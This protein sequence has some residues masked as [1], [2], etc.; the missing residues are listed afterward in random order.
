[1]RH[2]FFALATSLVALTGTALAEDS[3]IKVG[4][5]LEVNYTYNSNSPAATAVPTGLY[6]GNG[7]YFNK[8]S[9]EFSLNF[10]ELHIYKDKTAKEPGF[11]LR[12]VDGEVKPGLPLNAPGYNTSTGNLYEAVISEQLTSKLALD[13]GIF[14]TWVGYE[15][16]PM[17]SGNFFSKSFHFGQ[18]QPFYHG[19]VKASLT[20]SEKTTLVG[21]VV[22]RFSGVET[23]GNKDL[24]LGFQLAHVISEAS[25]IY[26]NGLASRDTVAVVPATTAEKQR[27]I[28]N[29]VYTRKLSG[30][31]NFA[32][33][34][35]VTSGKD[36]ANK[37]YNGQAVT[38]YYTTVLSNGNT[39]G[40]R[41]ESLTAD[42][43]T[44]W[45]AL[46]GTSKPQ[47]SSLTASYELKTAQKGVRTLVEVRFDSANTAIF[48]TKTSA[49]KN[50]TTVS[51]AHV[52][53]F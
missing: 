22:N 51:L 34:A 23:N 26:V 52:L 4:A 14:P 45:L 8:K 29:V 6:G 1:M 20:L 50:Q 11:S 21:T 46:G 37:T 19:G 38:G 43:N 28:A 33:D 25:T 3:G 7:Y 27:N 9:G 53:S 31:S 39:V 47:L 10:G 17:G 35:S 13:A 49:K 16:I 18:F 41:A 48:P 15:T 40:L 24:G 32:L 12:F 42:S 2:F 44:P 30:S 36:G 5:T